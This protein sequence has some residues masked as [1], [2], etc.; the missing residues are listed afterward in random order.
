VLYDSQVIAEYL[1]QVYAGSGC[2]RLY[3]TDAYLTAQ[4]RM[5][6]AL[7]AGTHKE[8]RPLFY[9]HVIRAELR[10][11]G[12]TDERVEEIVPAGVHPSYK[13]WLRNTISG[14]LR[15]DTSKQLAKET[16]QRKLDVMEEKLAGGG[17]LVGDAFTMADAAWFTRIDLLPVLGID[18]CR[19]CHPNLLR[20][21]ETIGRRSSIVA[22][23]RPV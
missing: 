23:R 1:E 18:L 13:Q 11:Q 21:Y 15:F 7:E 3:P 4:V 22:S 5:W 20:W 17:Y 16:I 2:P 9:L 19:D 6:L 12:I 14:S 10:N 8:F